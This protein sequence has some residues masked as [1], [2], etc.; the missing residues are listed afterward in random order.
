MILLTVAVSVQAGE[1]YYYNYDGTIIAPEVCDSVVTV[2]LDS[3]YETSQGSKALALPVPGIRTDYT[4][5]PQ[6]LGYY[7][8]GVVPGY[9]LSVLLDTLWNRDA[10]RLVHNLYLRSD[11]SV[12]ERHLSTQQRYL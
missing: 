7:Q 6:D 10:I 1:W 5:I 4:P 3:A 9:D 11:G 12:S 2:M 8:F